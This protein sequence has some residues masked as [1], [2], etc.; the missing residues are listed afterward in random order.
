ME[1]FQAALAEQRAYTELAYQRLGTKMDAGFARIDASVERLERKMDQF[2][3]TQ[4]RTNALVERRLQQLQ[5]L[6]AR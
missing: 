2:I 5:R 3:D 6:A 1:Q 4:S